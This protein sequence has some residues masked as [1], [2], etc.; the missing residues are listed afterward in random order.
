MNIHWFPGHM[1]KSLRMMEENVKLID[2]IIYVLD[3]RAP[4]SC[5]NPSFEPLIL[6]KKIIYVLNKCDLVRKQDVDNWTARINGEG[7][8]VIALSSVTSNSCS[9]IPVIAKKM[10]EEKLMRAKAKGIRACIRAMVIGVPNCGKSTLINNICQKGKTV[11]GNKAGVTRG[12]QWVAVNDYFELLDTPGTLYPKLSDVT[13]AKHLAYIGSIRDEVVDTTELCSELLAE[14]IKIAPNSLIERYNVQDLSDI[15]H[16]MSDIAKNR[17][18]L[19][20]GGEPN[21]DRVATAL[22]DDFRKGKLGKICL[23]R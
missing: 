16:V 20:K 15:P 14:L 17:G 12:K 5:I 23:D 2:V 22:M 10:C 18:Y 13:A 4:K 8:E 6:G 11:T 1:T 9:Q 7:N 21:F 3:A 19:F